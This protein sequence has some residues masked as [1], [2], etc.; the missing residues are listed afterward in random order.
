[1]LR[2]TSF[3]CLGTT[4][5]IAVALSNFLTYAAL[6]NTFDS[7]LTDIFSERYA[8]RILW[9][10][11]SE[12][13]SRLFAQAFRLIGEQVIPSVW[14]GV[15]DGLWKSVHDRLAM[16]LGLHEL[17]SRYD[18]VINGL[19]F[20]ARTYEAIC[21]A[22]IGAPCSL[23]PDRFIKDRISFV[24]LAFRL[25]EEK[26]KDRQKRVEELVARGRGI[27][28]PKELLPPELQ[29]TRPLNAFESHVEELNE[30]FRRA[31]APLNYH[32]GFIQITSDQLIEENVD[33]PFWV[34]LTDA[35]W[36]NVDIDM[37]EAVDR[38][39]N[40]GRDPAFYAARALESTVKVISDQRGWTRGNEP[41]AASHID[42]LISKANGSFI[43]VWEG[44]ILKAFFSKVRN[45]LG[46]GPG[47]AQMISLTP[48]QTDWAIETSMSWIKSLIRRFSV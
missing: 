41:G 34:L 8:N 9:T 29:G 40:G 6:H 42:N 20:G 27:L 47:S 24:E 36:E 35:L 44:E 3:L 25:G 10:A 28:I 7:M 17:A 13:E 2:T 1:M 26:W 48:E 12:P 22:F 15:A 32:N 37:K 39:D 18:R 14:D 33:R 45:P 30:R 19:E 23:S 11:H 21:K 16:E 4:A 5:A 46:H 38:R 43:T 31:G